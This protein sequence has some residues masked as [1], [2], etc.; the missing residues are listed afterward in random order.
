MH[1][2]TRLSK[3]FHILFLVI[4]GITTSSFAAH[5]HEKPATATYLANEGIM[6]ETKGY[7]VL[8]DPFFHNNYGNYQLVPA[9]ILASIMNNT[10]PYHDINAIFVSHSHGDHFAAQDMVNYLQ[11]YAEVKLIAPNQAIEQ[12]QEM[13]GFEQVKNQVTSISLEYGDAPQSIEVDNI[14]VDAV[15]IPHAGWPGRSNVANIVYRVTLPNG[16]SASTVIH[17]GDADPN[18]D[19][20]R[21]LGAFWQQKHTNISF[22]PY[23]FFSS[24]QGNY[25]LDN[26]I[27]AANHIGVHVPIN[28]P[29]ILKQSG[30][31]YFYVPGETRLI[32]HQH[33]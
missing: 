23:W 25:I 24:I 5:S 18:D 13:V 29:E 9:A 7:K 32:S 27:N 31:D 22:P 33:K 11:K 26:R 16:D 19:H 14:K 4:V 12:M 8:F 15:R 20:F 30:K 6:I 21:P 10:A 3:A 1:N 17:M 28:V 2:F